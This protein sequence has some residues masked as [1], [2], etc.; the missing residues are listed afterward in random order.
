M[1]FFVILLLAIIS[2]GLSVLSLRN[3]KKVHELHEAKE[4]LKT[5]RV[6]FQKDSSIPSSE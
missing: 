4:D 1:I 5:H 6:V 2:V 3:L